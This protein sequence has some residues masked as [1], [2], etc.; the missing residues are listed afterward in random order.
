LLFSYSYFKPNADAAR[1]M[2]RNFK[3]GIAGDGDGDEE[4]DDDGE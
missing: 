1:F 2:N 4:E 3:T